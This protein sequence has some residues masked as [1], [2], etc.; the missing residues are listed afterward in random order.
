MR[1]LLLRSLPFA[2]LVGIAVACGSGSRGSGFAGSSGSGSG[3]GSGNGGGNGSSSS[4]GLLGNSSSGSSGGN[5]GPCM[6][7][8]CAA[9][10]CAS[11]GKSETTLK[12]HVYDPAGNLP[13]YNV[14]V[15]IPNA[16]PAAIQPGDPT[17]T[18][19]EAP[20][21]G[22]PVIGVSTDPTGAFSLT[23]GP[24]D[25]WGVP[26][27]NNGGKGIPLVIQVGK[28]RKQLTIPSIAACT[29]TDLDAMFNGGTGT[30][31]QL[32]LPAKS[33]EGDMPLMAFT[34][35]C[36]PAECF[37]RHI[38]IDDSEFVAPSSPAPPAFPQTTAGAGHVHFYTG[39]DA[40][41]GPVSS[42]VAAGDTVQQ[43]YAWW[44]DSQ[45]LLKYD[46]VFNACECAPFGRGPG[47]YGAMDV[48]LRGGGRLFT[49]HYY[50]NWF[51]PSSATA[52]LQSVATWN[53]NDLMWGGN[54]PTSE[55]DAVDTSFPKGAAYAQWLQ[56]VGVYNGSTITLSDLR[57]DIQHPNPAGCST[58]NTCLSTRWIY[59]PA[60]MH[61]RYLSINTPVGTPVA[62]Q[63]GRAVYSDVH[64]SGQSDDAQFPQECSDPNIDQPPGHAINEKALEFLFFDLS[65]CVQNDSQPPPPPTTQ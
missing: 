23:K 7:L 29:T 52:D 6:G 27:G 65:S 47:S 18:P 21:S 8:E 30:A 2:V 44:T 63:C 59:N 56:N 55:N 17:C 22:Q 48:Y 28:W 3:G 26:T 34:A 12:G 40:Q 19:C 41:M 10:D 9:A 64:L 11:M 1:P 45:N 20:A 38:G 16:A 13:L 33:S 49:T 43:T 57:D 5:P 35:G 62:M 60:D 4:G 37:L 24:N 39:N 58:G 51:V 54:A 31:R 14:Y 46:I 53:S 61:P 42:S 50:G 15:Y 36:D 32:R 25:N